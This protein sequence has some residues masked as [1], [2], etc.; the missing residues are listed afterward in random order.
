MDFLKKLSLWMILRKETIVASVGVAIS[1]S[2]ATA[3]A[4]I[5]TGIPPLTNASAATAL[6]C[7]V[8]NVMFWV[9]ISVSII[10]VLWGAYLYVFAG[11]DAKRPSEA[12]MTILYAMIGIVIAL[13]AKGFP[14]LIASIFPGASITKCP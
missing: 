10:M 8:M 9:L 11:E 14:S 3:S 13:C 6:L 7:N 12:K 4:Q 1:L 5:S 2:A